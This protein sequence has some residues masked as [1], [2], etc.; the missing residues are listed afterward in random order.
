LIGGILFDMPQYTRSHV[1]GG[2]FFFTVALLERRH[3]LLIDRIAD[4][5]EVFRVVR[6]QRPFEIDAI[7]I[8][9]DHLHCLWTLPTDDPD[10]STRWRLIKTRFGACVPPGERLSARRRSKG[11]R[12][13]WQRRFWE[14][15][16]RDE[17]DYAAHV[18]YIHY[19]PVKHGYVTR[20]ADWPHSSIHR[21]M[22]DGRIPADWAAGPETDAFQYE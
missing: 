4:L 12:G 11:E 1:P 10:Y 17:A 20:A 5:R 3:N 14:H 15:T 2:T 16:I 9:P 19:N 7:V 13:I 8:L 18:D 6:S 22:E 21:F